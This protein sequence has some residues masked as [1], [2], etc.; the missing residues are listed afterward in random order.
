MFTK[1]GRRRK[2]GKQDFR[3]APRQRKSLEEIPIPSREIGIFLAD[4]PISSEE[5]HISLPKIH[6]SLEEI[7][8]SSRD[9]CI[10]LD[11]S[12]LGQ[13]R[14]RGAAPRLITS[15]CS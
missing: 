6:K 12:T 9:L 7:G 2:R 1:E 13:E 11:A 3:R 15:A 14:P 4:L 5:I 8:I 10:S